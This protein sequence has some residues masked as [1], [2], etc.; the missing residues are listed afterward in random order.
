MMPNLLALCLT[1][2][3]SPDYLH[4][5]MLL[6]SFTSDNIQNENVATNS[7]HVTNGKIAST[8]QYST[9]QYSTVQYSTVN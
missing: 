2:K 3:L 1:F 5:K 9:V 6:T 8:V 7:Y 4:I